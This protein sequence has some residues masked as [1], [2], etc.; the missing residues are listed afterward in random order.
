M[1]EAAWRRAGE[2]PLMGAILFYGICGAP[3]LPEDDFWDGE[4]K[5][6]L[7]LLNVRL[8][9]NG[10]APGDAS[11]IQYA[12]IGETFIDADRGAGESLDLLTIQPGTTKGKKGWDKTLVDLCARV[13][14]DFSDL[15]MNGCVGWWLL[16]VEE[17]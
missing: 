14:W 13:G 10:L 1:A 16:S 8:G 9:T 11:R 15:E 5:A 17:P 12:A 6:V 3:L 7:F 4:R 2:E